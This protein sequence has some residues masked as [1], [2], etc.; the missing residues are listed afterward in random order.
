MTIEG[1][2]DY[3]GEVDD[4]IV[5]GVNKIDNDDLDLTTVTSSSLVL[6]LF[7]IAFI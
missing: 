7:I 6:N 2:S 5:G 1:G 4:L 3:G